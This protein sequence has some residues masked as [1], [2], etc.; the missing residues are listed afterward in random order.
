MAVAIYCYLTPHAPSM[1]SA[2]SLRIAVV[3]FIHT[4]KSSVTKLLQALCAPTLTAMVT[5]RFTIENFVQHQ[6]PQ[7][8]PIEKRLHDDDLRQRHN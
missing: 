4:D 5:Q 6:L 2:L 7:V 8:C 3:V 1:L